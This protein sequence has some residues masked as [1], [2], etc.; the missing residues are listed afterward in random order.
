MQ[1]SC[2]SSRR[3]GSFAI[4]HGFS[5]SKYSLTRSAMRITSRSDL[6]ELARLVGLRDLVCR[7]PQAT[8]VEPARCA[9]VPRLGARSDSLPSKCFV[10]N[11]AARLAM[12]TY[13]PIRSLLTRATKSSG[14]KSMSSTLALSFAAM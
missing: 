1:T 3:A 8:V 6:A 10:M 9:I 7:D 5:S 13:L 14:L 4:S 12:F 11:L 2:S